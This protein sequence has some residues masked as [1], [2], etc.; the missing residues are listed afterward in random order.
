MVLTP[1]FALPNDYHSPTG[2]S[3]GRLSLAIAIHIA[4]QFLLPELTIRRR[5]ICEPA[6]WM[7]MPKTPMDKDNRSET[8]QNDVWSPREAPVMQPKAKAGPVKI[9]ADT[10]LGLGVSPPNTRHHSASCFP[11]DNISHAD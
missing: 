1:G 11:I 6:P 4:G 8:R 3:Q 10:K 9:A 5:H 7:L 2:G